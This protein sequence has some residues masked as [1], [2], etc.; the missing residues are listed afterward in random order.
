DRL[1]GG[2]GNDTLSGGKGDDYYI[3]TQGDRIGGETQSGGTDTLEANYSILLPRFFER[4]V[5]AGSR[6]IN[7]T[8]NDA[9]N[10]LI[11]NRAANRLDGGKGRDRLEGGL[12]NDSYGVENAGDRVVEALNEGDDT[13]FTTVNFSL[14]DAPNVENLVL[15]GNAFSGIGNGL[16]NEITGNAGSDNLFGNEGDD[17]L[18]G[19]VGDDNLDGGAGDDRLTGNSG[20]NVLVGGAGTDEFA[21]DG[22]EL[23]QDSDRISDFRSGVDTIVLDK[24][25]FTEIESRS[26]G[27]GFS[28]SSEF[29]VVD[30]LQDVT[31]SSAVIVYEERSGRLFYHI[32]G[33]G[34]ASALFVTIVGAPQL[35]ASDFKIES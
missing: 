3:L 1:D 6:T 19:S 33:R 21:F 14:E 35:S 24:D 30:N 28:R 17:E 27:R 15:V 11:G 34:G 12:G 23:G 5:L 29:E 20:D 7:A 2:A 25:T 26:G 13:I 32:N 8:G 4:V 31:L 18:A 22:N 10:T 9:N 16:N